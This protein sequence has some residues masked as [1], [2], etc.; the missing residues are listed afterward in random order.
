MSAQD[1]LPDRDATVIRLRQFRRQREAPQP[2]E[3]CEMCGEL[4]GAEHGHVVNI[5][6]RNLMCCCRSCYLLFTNPA[7]GRGKYRAVPE[8][9]LRDPAFT[10]SDRDWE[11]LQI[12]VNVAFFFHNS[13]MDHTVGFYPS[14]A[15]A[16]ESTLP[17]Q[18]WDS[19][20]G[21]SRLAAQLVPDVEA[22]L[23]RRDEGGGYE[24]QL[25]PI[26][27]CYELVGLVRLHWK[28]FGGGAE[29]W[30]AIDDFFDRLRERCRTLEA[31]DA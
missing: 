6:G 12:P 15:G 14:P 22:L 13:T 9:Y 16:T 11:Q 17:M 19:V 25:A 1:P 8:R 3:V 23:I 20:F 10:I 2:G 4:I 29:A 30:R 5:E 24:C 31:P 18:T 28:G 7:A 21:A 26:D 27:T